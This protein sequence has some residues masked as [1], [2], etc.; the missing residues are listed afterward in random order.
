MVS[1]TA[2][3]DVYSIGPCS[4]PSSRC[5]RSVW[6][7]AGSSWSSRCW[8]GLTRW[9]T[10]GTLPARPSSWPFRV[11]SF[12]RTASRWRRDTSWSWRKT[13]SGMCKVGRIINVVQ[14]DQI[15][16]FIGLRA[17]LATINL[18][19]SPTFL[20]NFCK[21]VKIDHFSCEVNFGQLL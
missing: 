3:K 1:V 21:G 14:C 7:F 4:S 12:Q 10:I 19:K 6:W 20:D 16:R 9:T 5:G 2:R 17:S 8:S 13:R 11:A 15:G 18:P